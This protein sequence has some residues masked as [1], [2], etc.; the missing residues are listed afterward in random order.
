MPTYFFLQ[1]THNDSTSSC[2]DNINL[3]AHQIT[4]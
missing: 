2:S 3:L 4:E 1:V